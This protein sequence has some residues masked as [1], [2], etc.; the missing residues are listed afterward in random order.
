MDQSKNEDA[1][2][3]ITNDDVP[4]YLLERNKEQGDRRGHGHSLGGRLGRTA[5]NLEP[6]QLAQRH[7]RPRVVP[8]HTEFRRARQSQDLPNVRRPRPTHLTAPTH[9]LTQ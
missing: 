4:L 8:I 1:I 7:E 5:R 3:V 2:S 9:Y 6:A